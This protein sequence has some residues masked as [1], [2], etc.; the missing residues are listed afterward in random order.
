MTPGRDD[1]VDRRLCDL[2]VGAQAG[3]KQSY[4]KLLVEC[5]P[6]IR[7]A[8]RRTGARPD[9]VD[10]IVQ[11]TLITL[12]GARQT[13]DPSRSFTAWLSVIAQRRAIDVLRRSGRIGGREV[14]APIELEQHADP[15]ADASSGWRDASRAE[16]LAKA[17]A[18]L[19][20]GQREAVELIAV[21]GRSLSEASAT[22]GRTK[23]ALKVNFHRALES[24]KQRLGKD[25]GRDD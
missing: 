12:H 5:E 23:G 7:R 11:E 10:D 13:F 24:L 14:H 8:A 25:D 1:P 15:A 19:T 16:D 2:M 17:L 4:A 3:N 20:P 18:G 9:L 6:I 21:E 22:T